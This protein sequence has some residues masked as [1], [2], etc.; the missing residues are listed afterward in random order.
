[1]DTQ[2]VVVY[3]FCDDVLKGLHH[4]EDPQRQMSDAEVMTTAIVAAQY[5]AGNLEKSSIFL[6]EHGYIPKMLEKSRFN[7]RMHK[8]SG[9]FLVVFNLLGEVWKQLNNESVYV[10]DS[11]PIS[12]CDNYRIMRSKRYQGEIWPGFQASKKRYFYGLKI[13]LMI[14]AQGQPVEF[15]L[16]PGSC[17]DT[18]ALKLY[19]FDLPE[20]SLVTGDKAYND[21]QYEDM[22]EVAGINL[23]PLRKRNS[24]RPVPSWIQYL[25]AGYRKIIETTGS[26][27]EKLLPKHI[28]AVTPQGFEL[29]VAIFILATSFNFLNVAT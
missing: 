21:Y 27:I 17:S 28:H 15:F 8:I 25:M 26:L 23:Q 2:I 24:H 16:T 3:C 14:T 6:Q 12:A 29:K 18:K 1:M 9:L 4:D 19:N 22:L 20:G 11:F 13:H 7:R 5:F 10:I